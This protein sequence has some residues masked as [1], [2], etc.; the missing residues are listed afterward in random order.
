MYLRLTQNA[1]DLQYTHNIANSAIVSLSCSVSF[2]LMEDRWV[3][4]Y[5]ESEVMNLKCKKQLGYTS[6]KKVNSSSRSICCE[7]VLRCL[8][9]NALLHVCNGIA[10]SWLIPLTCFVEMGHGWLHSTWFL[11][12][13]VSPIHQLVSVAARSAVCQLMQ[14]VLCATMHQ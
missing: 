5:N 12:Q 10:P 14:Q 8:C 9:I 7:V 11:Y 3:V 4:G 6:Q 1:L 2:S 13:C